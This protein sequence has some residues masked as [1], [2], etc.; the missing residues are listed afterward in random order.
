MDRETHHPLQTGT[1]PGPSEVAHPI[2]YRL[3]SNNP[4]ETRQGHCDLDVSSRETGL[5]PTAHHA[6]L[7]VQIMHFL[8]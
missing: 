7:V 4:I 5:I 1:I 3:Q 2:Y 6:A 8:L